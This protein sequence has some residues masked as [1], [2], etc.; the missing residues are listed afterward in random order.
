VNQLD[1][2]R[3]NTLLDEM[4]ESAKHWEEDAEK[5]EDWNEV[6]HHQGK[7]E[8]IREIKFIVSHW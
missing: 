8:A 3:L 4:E 5:R 2:E 6:S 1:K 7:R